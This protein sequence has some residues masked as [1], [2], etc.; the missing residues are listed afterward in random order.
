ML[1]GETQENI[2]KGRTIRSPPERHLIVIFALPHS[3]L[4]TLSPFT[5]AVTAKSAGFSC[6]STNSI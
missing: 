6:F 5:N 3:H 4:G 1:I 2:G